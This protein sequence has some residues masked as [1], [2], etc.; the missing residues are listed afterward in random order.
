VA[1][2]ACAAAAGLAGAAPAAPPAGCGGRPPKVAAAGTATNLRISARDR[3]ALRAAVVRCHGATRIAGPL[4]GSVYYARYRGFDWAI[5]T[6]SIGPA[7]TTD[8]PE[9]FVRRSGT[10]RWT[11]LG[12][13]GGPLSEHGLPCP[14]LRVWRLSC[15]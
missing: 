15:G 12:D 11:D 8:Q 14:V 3:A 6:F 5:A 10:R 13:T 7:R 1:T 2:V 9:R 4:Q